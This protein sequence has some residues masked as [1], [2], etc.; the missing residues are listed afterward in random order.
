[1]GILGLYFV[2]SVGTALVVRTAGHTSLFKLLDTI[3]GYLPVIGP[4]LLLVMG[5]RTVLK[6]AH[7]G[8]LGP[9][10]RLILILSIAAVPFL[11][12]MATLALT[13]T[14]GTPPMRTM[15]GPLSLSEWFFMVLGCTLVMSGILFMLLR[16]GEQWGSPLI[17]E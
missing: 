6:S 1:M 16:R 9:L 4:A 3:T 8:S 17:P 12:H 7:P 14:A 2:T 13:Y 11:V 15:W 5:L 10:L